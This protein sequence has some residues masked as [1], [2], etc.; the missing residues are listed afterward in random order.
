MIKIVMWEPSMGTYH[1][2]PK[3]VSKQQLD[4]QIYRD[5]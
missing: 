1:R 4:K 2:L 5:K 3:P